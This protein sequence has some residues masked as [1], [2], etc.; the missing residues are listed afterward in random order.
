MVAGKSSLDGFSAFWLRSSVV[1]SAWPVVEWT[2]GVEDKSMIS[3]REIGVSALLRFGVGRYG[4]RSLMVLNSLEIL[5][6]EE[7]TRANGHPDA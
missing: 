2:G 4:E 7:L 3:D 5:S 1:K 6:L